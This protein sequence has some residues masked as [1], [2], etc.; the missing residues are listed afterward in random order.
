MEQI[1]VDF[2]DEFVLSFTGNKAS[3]EFSQHDITKLLASCWCDEKFYRNVMSYLESKG[4]TAISRLHFETPFAIFDSAL[5]SV[6]LHAAFSY[7]NSIDAPVTT[8]KDP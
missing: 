2:L 1:P 5:P 7:L 3:G 6:L 4:V 8:G